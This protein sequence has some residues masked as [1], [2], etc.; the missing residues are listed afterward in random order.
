[1]HVASTGGV[2]SALVYGFGGMRDHAGGF[3]FDPR[4]PVGWTSLS[5]CVAWRGSR[6][7]V[8]LSQHELCVTIVEDGEPGVRV[9]VL[10]AAYTV[11]REEPLRVALGDQGPRIDGLLGDKPQTGGT[12]ADGTRITAGVPEPMQF[13]EDPDT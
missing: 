3:T 7:R 2:W 8:D 12:R 13:D 6:L 9:R 11:T 1:M 5:F 10:G 4:L